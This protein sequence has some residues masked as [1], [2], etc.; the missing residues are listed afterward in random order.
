[1]AGVD[2]D[3]GSGASPPRP[4]ARGRRRCT[5]L[6]GRAAARVRRPSEGAAGP[7]RRAPRRPRGRRPLDFLAETADVRAATGRSRR[8]RPTCAT[9]ASRSPG[10][11]SARWLINALNSGARVFMADLEDA[12]S[13]TWAN[14]VGGQADLLRRGA[15][16]HARLHEPGGQG[17]PRSTQTTGDARWCGRA[18]GTWPSATCWSTA[19]RCR[20]ACSTSGCTCS[21][22]AARR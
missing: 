17:V 11:P 3:H 18:A 6:R 10:R 13:P 22:T 12:L 2:R 21:T 7:P 16:R 1:M 15:P 9:G 4:R 19:S 5:G 20:R 14:V 8:R